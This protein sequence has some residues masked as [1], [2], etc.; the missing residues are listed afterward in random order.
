MRPHP[1]PSSGPP[2]TASTPSP[3]SASAPANPGVLAPMRPFPGPRSRGPQRQIFVAGVG[4]SGRAGCSPAAPSSAARSIRSESLLKEVPVFPLT[5]RLSWIGVRLWSMRGDERV[6]D[7]MFSYLTLEQRVSRKHPLRELRRL[8]DIV[9]RSLSGEKSNQDQSEPKE[10]PPAAAFFNKL[11][12]HLQQQR[13]QQLLGSRRRPPVAGAHRAQLG[14]HTLQ[15]PV[16]KHANR[17]QGMVLGNS[18]QQRHATEYRRLD[19]SLSTHL[20]CLPTFSVQE[21]SNQGAFPQPVKP[22]R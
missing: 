21:N 20:S 1:P 19:C 4:T 6:Q 13:A 8:T 16:G 18:P 7:G 12:E 22:R 3:T 9:V 2:R 14:V 5:L 17:S 15:G 10:I 11:L